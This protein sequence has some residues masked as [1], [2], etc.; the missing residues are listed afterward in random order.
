[1]FSGVIGFIG[2]G[3]MAQAIAFGLIDAGIISS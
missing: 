1:M 2:A 3:N